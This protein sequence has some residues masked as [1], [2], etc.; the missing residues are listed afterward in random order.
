MPKAIPVL[1]SNLDYI[2]K[3]ADNLG[4]NLDYLPDNLEYTTTTYRTAAGEP[5]V[6][7]MITDGTSENHNVTF[8][9]MSGS[10]FDEYWTFDE[11][12]SPT[13]FR[14]IKRI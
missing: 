7:Y 10:A 8:T 13:E 11:L 4:F 6:L 5:E 1:E 12:E 3:Y 14:T 9:D 2:I